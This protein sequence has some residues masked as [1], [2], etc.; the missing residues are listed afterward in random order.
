MGASLKQIKHLKLDLSA[1]Y[2]MTDLEKIGSYLGMHIVCD[3]SLR[4]SEKD[5]SGYV[6]NV[7][8]CFGMSD[9]TP[10]PTPLP[11]GADK[12]LQKHMGKASAS[13]IMHYQSLIRSLLYVQIGT[14]L[15]ISFA[16][17]CLVQYAANPPNQ[18]LQ[19]AQYVLSYL[20]G[21]VDKKL[22]Y[23]G[24]D[25]DGIHGYTDSSLVDQADDR[26]STSGY[27]FL[28]ANG[29]ISWFLQKQKTV[30]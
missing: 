3:C 5:Q 8:E 9:A 10:H 27:E 17:S 11:A 21:T 25:R 18:H 30:A 26:H 23:D 16:V 15:D 2:E 28:L 1:H 22:V 13:D 24:T 6:K 19:L 20:V 7:L 14:Q 12:H 4:H 29:A